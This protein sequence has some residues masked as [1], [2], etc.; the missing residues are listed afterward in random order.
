M[1]KKVLASTLARAICQD[2][3][4]FQVEDPGKELYITHH[5]QGYLLLKSHDLTIGAH[6]PHDPKSFPYNIHYNT[7]SIVATSPS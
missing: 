6:F 3:R 1:K 5:D 7:K 2:Q 4:S